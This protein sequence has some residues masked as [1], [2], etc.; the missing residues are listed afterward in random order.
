MQGVPDIL[1]C[2][3]NIDFYKDFRLEDQVYK[4]H[5]HELQS[6]VV[7]VCFG[8]Y[9]AVDGT[10][11]ILCLSWKIA[12]KVFHIVLKTWKSK[13]GMLIRAYS[14]YTFPMCSLL[15]LLCRVEILTLLGMCLGKGRV[16]IND[17]AERNVV[18]R[19]GKSMASKAMNA[20]TKEA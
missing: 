7:P 15:L 19:N 10:S 16:H 2:C 13:I 14:M 9:L 12:G 17:F 11:P 5:L 4:N 3:Y 20:T 18:V 1:K 6:S 8:Y